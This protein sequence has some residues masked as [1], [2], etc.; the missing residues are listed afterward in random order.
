[1][2]DKDM[3]KNEID[4]LPENLLSEVFDFIQFLE[5]RREKAVLMK[6]SQEL[7]GSSFKKIWDNEEDAVYDSL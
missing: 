4:K 2:S 6:A 5:N 7:S 3:I 1:M